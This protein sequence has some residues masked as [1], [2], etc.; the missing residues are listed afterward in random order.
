MLKKIGLSMACLGLVFASPLTAANSQ[1]MTMGMSM[2]YKLIPN[3]PL[4]LYNFTFW[5]IDAIC[6]ITTIDD[7]NKVKATLLNR[8]GAIN[9]KN[10][11][12]GDITH[13]NVR[14]GDNLQISAEAHAKVELVNLGEHEVTAKCST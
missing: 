9:G 11:N 10:L 2:T 4:E 1:I 3:E 14:Q 7:E 5:T 6:Q 13:V 12:K 8:S